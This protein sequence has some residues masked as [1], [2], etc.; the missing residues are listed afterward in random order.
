MRPS[1]ILAV[2]RDI[3][4]REIGRDGEVRDDMRLVQDLGLDSVELLALAVGVENHF[5]IRIDGEDEAGIATVGDL[6][7]VVA[8]KLSDSG[9]A[10]QVG[11]S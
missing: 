6:V 9:G 11:S 8:S 7:R 10:G 2:V 1:E 5:R 3:A 4:R